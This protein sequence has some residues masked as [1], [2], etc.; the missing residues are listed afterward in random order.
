MVYNWII[1]GRKARYTAFRSEAKMIHL[2]ILWS[3]QVQHKPVG[4][5]LRRLRPTTNHASASP[6]GCLLNINAYNM[7]SLPK[8]SQQSFYDAITSHIRA[9]A[10]GFT[11]AGRRFRIEGAELPESAWKADLKLNSGFQRQSWEGATENRCLLLSML[12]CRLPKNQKLFFYLFCIA[13]C[14]KVWYNRFKT[15]WAYCVQ[16][17]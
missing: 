5:K 9:S 12:L 6:I 10:V 17:R 2:C 8:F 14:G 1:G 7:F 16:N 11:P 13:I 4:F 3:R 15:G